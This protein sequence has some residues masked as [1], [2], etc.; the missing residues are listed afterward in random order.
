MMQEYAKS[1]GQ[2]MF[3]SMRVSFRRSPPSNALTLGPRSQR[4]STTQSSVTHSAR[5]APSPNPFHSTAKK[6]ARC[7]RLSRYVSPPSLPPSLNFA[8]FRRRRDPLVS[9]R[10]RVPHPALLGPN[11]HARTDGSQLCE[12]CGPREPRRGRTAAGDQCSVRCPLPPSGA[13]TNTGIAGSRRLRKHED[14]RWP[15]SVPSPSR[16]LEN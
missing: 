2:T 4:T 7:S 8:A 13:G 16:S 11:D 10:P 14:T 5:L 1:K 15:R 12:I 3:I 6:S 9:P